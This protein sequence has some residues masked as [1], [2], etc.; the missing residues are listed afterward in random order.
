MSL[1]TVEDYKREDGKLGWRVTVGEGDNKK[2]VA[3]DGGQ[4]Y[5]NKKDML[6]SFFGLFFGTYD[7]SFLELYN[8]WK[9]DGGPQTEQEADDDAILNSETGV[10]TNTAP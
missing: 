7:E 10:T 2:V 8:E 3:T 5:E 1:H 9:P 4:G 6:Q